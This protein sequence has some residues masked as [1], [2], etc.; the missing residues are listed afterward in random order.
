MKRLT[1]NLI[2][3]SIEAFILALETIN[4]PSVRYR[5]ETFC[6]LFCNSWELLMKAKILSDGHKIFHRKKRNQTRRSLSLDECL[7]YI[8]M[9]ENNPMKLNIKR[10]SELRNNAMHL[11]I[12][13]I[14]PDIMGLFQ[15]GVL[16]YPKILQDW[17]S[18]SLSDRVPL[19][20]MAL[21]YDFDP[22]K[23]SL[24]YAKMRRKLPAETVRWVTDFQQEVRRRAAG[25]GDKSMQFYIPIDLKLAIVKNP[26]KAEI[27]LSS[28]TTGEEALILEVPKD[29]DK[30]HPHR[31]KEVVELVNQKLGGRSVI[32]FYDVLCIRKVYNIE[33]RAEFYYKSKHWSPQYSDTFVEWVIRQAAKTTNFFDRTRRKIRASQRANKE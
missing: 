15:A 6:I 20:M 24:E 4:R 19:G 8:F 12:P 25:L 10:I 18:I 31:A 21:V 13:F 30:T 28:S 2:D 3:S 1:K 32:N 17:F 14:P 9:F 27:V 22:E 11:V 23:H 16:N 29:I 5:I 7:D 33:Y 26:S